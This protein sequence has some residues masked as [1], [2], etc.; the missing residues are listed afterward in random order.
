[1]EVVDLFI[2]V[3]DRGTHVS[4]RYARGALNV[5]GLFWGSIFLPF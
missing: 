3:D 2:M 4:S 1:M 5:D